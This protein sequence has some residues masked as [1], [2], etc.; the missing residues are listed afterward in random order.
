MYAFS[1]HMRMY[2]DSVRSNPQRKNVEFTYILKEN[3]LPRL[4]S[5]VNNVN[6]HEP[7]DCGGFLSREVPLVR[8]MRQIVFDKFLV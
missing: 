4:E 8:L 6:G 1:N 2:H 3:C 5:S 7:I